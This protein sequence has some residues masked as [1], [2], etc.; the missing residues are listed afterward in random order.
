MKK[1][2]LF[3]NFC[4]FIFITAVITFSW[5]NISQADLYYNTY[6]GTGAYP[7]TPFY[8]SGT[9]Y[10]PTVLSTGTVTS[11]NHDWGS[12]NVLDSGLSERVIVKYWGYIYVPVA[13]YSQTW[14]FYNYSDDGFYMKINDTVVI[15]DWQ[16]QG[17]TLYNGSGSITLAG[18][19]YH[20]IEVWYYENGGDAAAGL[21]WIQT[22]GSCWPL[23]WLNSV[24]HVPSSAYSLTPPVYSSSITAAQQTR[25]NA[26]TARTISSSSVYIDQIGDNNTITVTQIGSKNQIGGVGQQ[27]AYLSGDNNNITVRQGNDTA[28]ASVKNQLELR[29]IG[30][31][32]TLNINQGVTTTNANIS[33]TNGHYQLVDISGSSNSLTT[34][35]TNTGGAGEHYMETTIT[36]STNAVT[37][38]QLDNGSKIMFTS[39]NGSGNIMNATQSGTG[40]HYLDATLTGNG[41]TANITQ[42]GSVQHKATIALTNAGGASNLSL[43][44]NSDIIGQVYSIQQSCVTAG[45][46]ATTISQQ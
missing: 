9:L 7:S 26:F 32:N 42:S 14:T 39:I 11:I 44:Q 41:H 34:Q 33:S 25:V 37:N 6:A 18:G 17:G 23:C 3:F 20:L 1:H 4:R 35:Q 40:Q 29:V 19:Q 12:G 30:S 24:V 27:A 31:T 13:G 46:C 22:G 5:I 16:E 2:F 43:T 21:Y 45:G 8:G 38:M 15:D 36:G 10:Y 28:A